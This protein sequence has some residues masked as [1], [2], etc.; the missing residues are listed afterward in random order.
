[1]AEYI[2]FN[3]WRNH[4]KMWGYDS[5][6]DEK[7][8]TVRVILYWGRIADSLQK[9]QQKEK[10]MSWGDAYSYIKEK[11]DDKERKGY[12]PIKN[13]QYGRYT[14]GEISLS[15]LIRIIEVERA[16]LFDRDKLIGSAR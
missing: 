14:I 7:T 3:I 13:W 12:V 4:F 6:Q 16:K 11:L 8:G 10:F 9:L 15:E 2:Y 1:M 5:F